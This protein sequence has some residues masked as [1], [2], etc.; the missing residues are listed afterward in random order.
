[1]KRWKPRKGVLG[2]TATIMLGGLASLG[3]GRFAFNGSEFAT[4]PSAK[5]LLHARCQT[6]LEVA[7]VG[8]QCAGVASLV[9]SRLLP[10][11]RWA[12]RGRV[13]F[14][15]SMVGLGLSGTVCAWYGSELALFG[16]ATMAVLLNVVIMGKGPTDPHRTSRIRR[17]SESFMTV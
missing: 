8:F 5:I 14:I 15:A 16:G 17:T 4:D 6:W 11:S 7:V 3:A 2:W 1:M 10:K 13:A 9:L 12:D